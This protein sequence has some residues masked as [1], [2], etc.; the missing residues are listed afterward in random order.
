MFFEDQKCIFC[1][2][3]D[4]VRKP[5]LSHNNI[6]KTTTTSS[7]S[8]KPGKI[9]DKY[10]SDAKEEIKKEKSRLRSEEK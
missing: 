8:S 10:I 5:S 1:H 4:V 6:V 2:S 3:D 9:V 7:K